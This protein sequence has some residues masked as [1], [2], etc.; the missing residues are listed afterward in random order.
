MSQKEIR[1][2][3]P[4][5]LAFERLRRDR[6][7][8]AALVMIGMICLIA[9]FAPV[10]AAIVGHAPEAQYRETG[11]SPSGIPVGPNRTFLFGTDGLGRDIL[12]RVAYGARISL[13]VGVVSSA[14]AVMV[15]A[16]VGIA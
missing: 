16:I 5:E 15:G 11:L 3:G 12:V 8:I 6:A 10:V 2:R 4:W 14:L 13:L 9:V 7:A 1:G